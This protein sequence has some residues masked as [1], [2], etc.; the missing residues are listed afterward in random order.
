MNVLYFF[1]ARHQAISPGGD[2]RWFAEPLKGG[3]LS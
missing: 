2:T 3:D 1:Q